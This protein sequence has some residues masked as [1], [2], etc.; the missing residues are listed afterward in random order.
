LPS[1]ARSRRD[2]ATAAVGILGALILGIIAIFSGEDD[3]RDC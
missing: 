2:P 3:R 1:A